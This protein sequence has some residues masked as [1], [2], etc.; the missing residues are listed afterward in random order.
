MS[1]VSQFCEDLCDPER[2]H[3]SEADGPNTGVSLLRD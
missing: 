3:D 1:S 2:E